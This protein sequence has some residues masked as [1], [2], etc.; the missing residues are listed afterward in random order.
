MGATGVWAE[1]GPSGAGW[2]AWPGGAERRDAD[3]EVVLRAV[4]APD[5][6]WWWSAPVPGPARIGLEAE[7][8]LRASGPGV[9]DAAAFLARWERENADAV[10]AL[11]A[12]GR[13]R[14]ALGREAGLRVWRWN[15]CLAAYAERLWAVELL[16]CTPVAVRLVAPQHDPVTTLTAVV[17]TEGEPVAL[18]EADLL[19]AVDGP[20]AVPRAVPMVALRPWLD[21][22]ERRAASH[23]FGR[24]GVEWDAGLAHWIVDEDD[25]AALVGAVR[26]LGAVRTLEPLWPREVLD[27]ELLD[28]VRRARVAVERKPSL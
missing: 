17:W 23:Q 1:A 6:G 11:A 24:G 26:E 5:G 18:P 28:A 22:L 16:P 2:S 27:R 14:R 25:A 12:D 4:A 19:L 9:P 8:I 15:R 21:R 13:P 20:D 10:A 3:G 7:A